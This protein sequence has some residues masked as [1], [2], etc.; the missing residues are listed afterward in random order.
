MDSD[1]DENLVYDIVN[2]GLDSGGTCRLMKL[3]LKSLSGFGNRFT[4]SHESINNRSEAENCKLL[5]IGAGRGE[6]Y[7]FI[8]GPY[9][10]FRMTD[11]SDRGK[12][13]IQKICDSDPRVQFEIQ[14]VQ[15]LTYSDAIFDRVIVSC[16]LAHVNEPFRSF[17]E[18]KRVTK[19]G[20]V[21]SIFISADPGL[22]L[23]ILR[24][25]F[26]LRK[27]RNEHFSYKLI[28]AIGHRNHAPGL[29]EMARRVFRNDNLSMSYYP[30]RVKSWNLATHVVIN[31]VV[32]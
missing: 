21:I 12:L 9:S 28:N 6:L 24:K 32:N 5:E 15:N 19:S 23:R 20:G 10:D 3:S 8:K 14:D 29:I 4:S 18:L 13:N 2:G 25:L 16:V 31:V 27:M 7:P 17:E 22:L 1:V 11:I 26:V 30:F